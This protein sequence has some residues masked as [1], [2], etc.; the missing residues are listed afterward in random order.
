[1]DRTKHMGT[2]SDQ[3][4]ARTIA[5]RYLSVH[6]R[7]GYTYRPFMKR[8]IYRREDYRYLADLKVLLPDAKLGT[9]SY[10]WGRYQAPMVMNLRFALIPY[11]PIRVFVNGVLA[12]QSDIFSERARSKQ[13]FEL[14]MHEGFND[15]VL[16]CENTSGGFGG[17]F[18]TWVGKLDYYFLM[19]D[20]YPEQEGFCYSKTLENQLDVLDAQHLNVL[21]WLPELPDFKDDAVDLG[22]IFN[23]ASAQ[24]YVVVATALHLDT[25]TWCNV[26]C[27]AELSIDGKSITGSVELS[28]G[29]HDLVCYA[30]VG[31]G[32]ELSIKEARTNAP[33]FCH[34][35]VLDLN[36]SYRYLFAGP[37]DMRPEGFIVQCSKPFATSQGQDF[38]HLE[39]V[40]TYLRM[41]ND[42]VLF[43]HWNYPLGVTLYGLVETERMLKPTEPEL[44]NRIHSYINRH[45]QSS[46]D[47]YAYA[48]W[49]AEHLGGAT[50]V[51][52]LMTS[53]DSLDDCGSFAST[54]LE[55]AKDHELHDY[56][57][58]MEV[59]GNYLS[60][61]QPRLSD[62]TFFRTGLMHTFHENTLWVDDLYMSVPFLCRYAAYRNNPEYLEDAVHQFFGFSKY[63]FLQEEQ[64]M[65]HVYDF[66]RNL[67]TGIPWGRGNGWALFSLSEL[68]TVLDVD[69]PKRDALLSLF[70]G[71]SKGVLRLQGKNGMFHQVLDMPQSYEESSCTAMFACSFSRGVRSGW[72]PD[73]EPYRQACL[74]AVQALKETAIDSEGHVWGVCRGSEFSCSRQYYAH[75]LLPRLDDT[76]GIGIVLLSLCEA[77]KLG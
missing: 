25:S 20:L 33:L 44:S 60:K 32:F 45:I 21:A 47:T 46:I 12:A 22:R 61:T 16:E 39:G 36:S 58:L 48:C 27:N 54:L 49:D 10:L 50:A 69:H 71:L 24:S 9:F 13:I 34:N 31:D 1:M 57:P 74:K 41:Y 52:H 18:G 19:P 5:S 64:L 17:E 76:H 4:A 26:I 15:V 67:V 30:K 42:N 68:L 35:P 59:V 38:W 3:E 37:F 51:H 53:L 14:V 8:G 11:G 75:Q 62:G 73:G 66:E 63:L 40:S 77:Q 43:G 7:G 29:D 70:Q 56:A 2:A 72:Y 23:D 55:V 28:E 6:E 65:S